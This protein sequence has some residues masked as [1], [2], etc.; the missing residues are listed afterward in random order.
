MISERANYIADSIY[1]LYGTDSG[2]LFGIPSTYKESVYAVINATLLICNNN[3]I[4]LSEVN[5]QPDWHDEDEIR[6]QNMRD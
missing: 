6:C 1:Q 4:E 5:T 3:K 2:V